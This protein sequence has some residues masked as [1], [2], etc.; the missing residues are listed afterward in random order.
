MTNF[1]SDHETIQ[2][3]QELTELIQKG[4]QDA[5]NPEIINQAKQQV[6]S[7]E[8]KIQKIESNLTGINLQKDE[9]EKAIKVAT[10]LDSLIQKLGGT[11]K[12]K[13]DLAKLEDLN[14]VLNQISSGAK[15]A[16]SLHQQTQV[17]QEI[18]TPLIEKIDRLG[19]ADTLMER[20]GQLQEIAQRLGTL[21]NQIQSSIDSCLNTYLPNFEA[22]K[23]LIEQWREE[24]LLETQNALAKMEKTAE[25]LEKSESELQSI[26]NSIAQLTQS[27]GGK[28]LFNTVINKLADLDNFW[29]T[30]KSALN[31]F[32]N[33]LEE[34]LEN[35]IEEVIHKNE[36][37]FIQ[38]LTELNNVIISAKAEVNELQTKIESSTNKLQKQLETLIASE[39][40]RLNAQNKNE[41]KKELRDEFQ[42]LIHQE[43][44]VLETKYL[45]EI[46]RLDQ[47]NKRLK[48]S[49]GLT[50]IGLFGR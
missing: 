22:G 13:Q 31:K 39:C 9:L 42:N 6:E 32:K 19:G 30:E 46:D 15:V 11:N 48:K 16:E 2:A 25:E 49:F 33:D 18:I 1:A 10:Q 34:A 47:E 17:S 3:L 4:L 14:Q 5:W 50:S 45:Q 35:E 23:Y 44:E 21:D 20:F 38:K 43:I 27:L 36:G 40:K 37:I 24:T 41:L 29:V 12:I 8:N 7:I 26:L 28:T